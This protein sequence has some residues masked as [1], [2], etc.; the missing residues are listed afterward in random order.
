MR[1]TRFPLSSRH[2][3]IGV[4]IFAT[5]FA[6]ATLAYF[7][8]QKLVKNERL[9]AKSFKVIGELD[10]LQ[11]LIK[12][13]ETGQRSFILTG[14][15]RY[16]D[17]YNR[18]IEE[19]PR[20][21]DNLK[22]EDDD[23]NRNKGIEELE[24]TITQRIALADR[25]ILLRQKSGF[26][27]ARQF[28]QSGVGKRET[29]AINRLVSS[30]TMQENE[31]LETRA[32]ES[33]ESAD[34]ATRTFWVATLANITFLLLVSVLLWRT[35]VQNSRLGQAYSDLKRAEDMRDNLTAMLV[36]DLRTPLTSLIGPLEMLEQ[37]MLG[38]LDETQNEVVKMSRQSGQ[39]LLGL[40]NQLLDVSKMEAGEFKITRTNIDTKALLQRAID[41]TSGLE[42]DG[43][44]MEIETIEVESVNGDTELLER[45]LI[46]LLGNAQ[47]FSPANGAIT[48]GV[49]DGEK[50]TFYVQDNGPG[51]PAEY[52]EK[53]FDKFGQVE[54]R[55]DGKK[56]STGLGL[57]F[58]RL[59]VEAHGGRIWVESEAGRGA[60]FLFSV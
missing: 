53:I 32:I 6:D 29:D 11:S 38:P 3:F 21:L 18:A 54:S 19:I 26:E 47:K 37:E 8:I 12:D 13:I 1:S 58:C 7:S 59:A 42:L 23:V 45:V 5:L 43:A 25:G 48:L 28:I 35:G 40:V 9:I 17:S 44:Q 14:D 55:Q 36:H 20:G 10:N 52:R 51:I 4:L 31:R 60:R 39:R 49:L 33:T 41:I 57:T 15:K 46:N 50:P 27:P 30:L 56:F 2:I 16:L 22:S 34:D 24:K